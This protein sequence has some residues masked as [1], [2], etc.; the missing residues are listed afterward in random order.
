MD[1]WWSDYLRSNVCLDISV[2]GV[3]LLGHNRKQ[4]FDVSERQLFFNLLEICMAK[5][6]LECKVNSPQQ[7]L[8]N[9]YV[10]VFG[11]H[12][13]PRKALLCIFALKLWSQSANIL[14][15][16]VLGMQ[17]RS[18]LHNYNSEESIL[19]S[20]WKRELYGHN[21]FIWQLSAFDLS[22]W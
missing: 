6:I 14:P 16:H 5:L 20:S 1:D 15:L 11:L 7:H 10:N 17:P 21:S 3:K 12:L 4:I 9:D 8:A 13:I 18:K 2:F 22:K 19:R